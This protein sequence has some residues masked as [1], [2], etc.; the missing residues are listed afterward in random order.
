MAKFLEYGSKGERVKKLQRLINKNGYHTFSKKLKVD[1]QMGVRTCTQVH[2]LKWWMGYKN[3][4]P[5]IKDQIAGGR[6][7]AYL[8]G[9]RKLSANMM[10]RRRL[11]IR[12]AKAAAKKSS[13]RTKTLA[14]AKADLNIVEGANNNIKYNHWWCG[15]STSSS[16]NDGGAYCVRAGSYWNTKGGAKGVKRG[17]RWQNTDALLADAKAGRNGVHL[18][19]NPK[20]GNGFVIDWSGHSDPDHFGLYVSDGFKSLEANATIESGK[21]AGKQGVGYH[22]RNANQCWF[23]VF[24]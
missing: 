19:S 1:G 7:F 4:D 14:A 23:I 3:V 10:I 9:T 20:P 16:A 6:F 18:T 2:N 8:E 13:V 15:G 12:K 11:R 24:E 5:D 22:T 21:N 17:V